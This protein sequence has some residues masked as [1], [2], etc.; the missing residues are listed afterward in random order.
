[1]WISIVVALAFF[2]AALPCYIV[3]GAVTSH[4]KKLE[5]LCKACTAGTVVGKSHISS[6]G[7]TLPK[8][9]YRVN[10]ELYTTAGPKFAGSVNT[11]VSVGNR[12]LGTASSNLTTDEP[13]P[14]VV[15]TNVD[16]SAAQQMMWERY[17]VGKVVNV[18]YDPAK[19]KRAYVERLARVSPFFTFWMPAGIGALMTL[20]G[21]IL[22]I[23]H[24]F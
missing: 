9:E 8:V 4:F 18:F 17:P 1:M 2:L 20:T 24:P 14:D 22:L 19:P 3:A 10:G 7:I 5:M 23:V 12:R 21:L 15:K 16:R 11:Y 6:N 13:L